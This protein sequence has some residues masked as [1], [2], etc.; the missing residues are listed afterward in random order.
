MHKGQILYIILI[1]CFLIPNSV[2][3]FFI[4]DDISILNHNSYDL[5]LHLW[6]DV[7]KEVG[8]TTH[9]STAQIDDYSS[10]CA[11]NCSSSNGGP[12]EGTLAWFLVLGMM[13]SLGVIVIGF[14]GNLLT[15]CSIIHQQCLP[16]SYRHVL[17]MSSSV[18]LVLNLA[19]AD[20]LYCAFNLPFVF[21]IYFKIYTSDM[22]IYNLYI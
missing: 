22:V 2:E 11:R 17:T 21:Y 12:D 4:A 5:E 10:D 16:K 19:I 13:T 14:L 15:I 20:L 18:I 9:D 1:A 3:S 7:S 6:K 8:D